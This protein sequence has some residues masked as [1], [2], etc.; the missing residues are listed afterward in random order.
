[1][2]MNNKYHQLIKFSSFGVA[3]VMFLILLGLF[4][5]KSQDRIYEEFLV[6]NGLTYPGRAKNV[7]ARPGNNRIEIAWQRGSDP[8]VVNARIFWNNYSDTVE[9]DIKHDMDIISRIIPLKENTYSFMIHTYDAKGNVSVPVEVIGRVYGETY[10]STLTNRRLRNHS[11]SAQTLTLNWFEAA[12]TETGVNLI[13]DNNDTI[14]VDR[15]ETVTNIPNFDIN[16]QLF[17][18]TMHKPDSMAIDIFYAPKEEIKF[19]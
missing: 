4:S 13:L 15:S 17:Y 10:Q 18:N 2:K 19:D 5:C 9:V 12:K 3:G 16:R 8:K 7:V 1:M 6:P 14:V 11:Y